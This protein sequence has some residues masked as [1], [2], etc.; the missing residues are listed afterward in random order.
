MEGRRRTVAWWWVEDEA[1]S[2]AVLPE[3]VLA[4]GAMDM[5]ASGLGN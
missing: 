1:I 2:L 4:I 5:S 3:K